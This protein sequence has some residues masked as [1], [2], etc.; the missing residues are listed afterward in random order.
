MNSLGTVCEDFALARIIL[1]IKNIVNIIQIVVPL[2]LMLFVSVQLVKMVRDPE[3]KN[4]TKKIN[5]MF[6]AAAC[7]FF[8]PMFINILAGV[9]ETNFNFAACWNE[10]ESIS[11]YM[12]SNPK[13]MS[14]DDKEK[15][16]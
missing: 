16:G 10:A 7:V 3:L 2:L 13:Y 15:H 4:G 6:I 8:M 14:I 1:V 12:S 11:N 9:L 5:S